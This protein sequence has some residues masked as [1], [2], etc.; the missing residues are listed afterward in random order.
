[1][2]CAESIKLLQMMQFFGIESFSGFCQPG[3]SISSQ[4]R[5][6]HNKHTCLL[7]CLCNARCCLD[8]VQ[9]CPAICKLVVSKQ[10]SEWDQSAARCILVCA[11]ADTTSSC[12][13]KSCAIEQLCNVLLCNCRLD[14]CWL[15]N[16]C[17]SGTD[18]QTVEHTVCQGTEGNCGLVL[19][20]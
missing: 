1:M 13:C 18:T 19:E 12:Q 6:R 9:L 5:T 7:A 15:H 10:C 20:T 4:C 16:L 8:V 17:V 14:H 2:S 3:A 11:Q